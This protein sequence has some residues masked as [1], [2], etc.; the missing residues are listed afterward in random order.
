[1]D[2]PANVF[3]LGFLASLLAGLGTG[4]G[5]LWV[6]VVV[7]RPSERTQDALLS[8][9]AGIILAATFVSLLHRLSSMR[10]RRTL[11]SPCGSRSFSSDSSRAAVLCFSRTGTRRTNISSS[12][13]KDRRPRHCGEYGCS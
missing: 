5:A 8:A 13:E 3:W 6:L 2:D 12:A 9:A 10:G 11:R 4:L 7:A 1:V